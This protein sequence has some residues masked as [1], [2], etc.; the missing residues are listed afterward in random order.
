MKVF[1][2]ALL[3]RLFPELNFLCI[4]HEGK[5]DLEKSIPRKLRAWT[6]PGVRFCVLRDI[7]EGD[8]R[9]LKRKL[10]D[11]CRTAGREET[12]VRIACQELEAW[13]F[14]ASER[15]ADAFQAE[16][17]RG[18]HRKARFRDPDALPDPASTLADL[19]PDFQKISGARRLGA[20]LTRENSSRSF[21]VFLAGVERLARPPH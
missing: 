15:I 7:D 3:P 12:L 8:C 2:E 9:T 17:M 6:E 13:Y 10:R 21:Q 18:I 14:G 16:Q 11:L 5:S 4:P 20:V 19:V 1:L